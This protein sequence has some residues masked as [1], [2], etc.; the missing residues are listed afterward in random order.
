M[1]IAPPQFWTKACTDG[2][3][4]AITTKDTVEDSP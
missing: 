1:C 3:T 4:K 2:N